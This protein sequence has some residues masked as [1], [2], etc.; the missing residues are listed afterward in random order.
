MAKIDCDKIFVK[1]AKPTSV[2]GQ[3]VMDGVMM[4]GNGRIALAMRIPSGEIYLKSEKKNPDSK[5]MK[6]PFV[7]GIV[8]FVSSLVV[9]MGKL[10]ESADVLA[11]YDP[12]IQEEEKGKVEIWIE[13]KF[14]KKA[15]WNLMMGFSLVLALVIT[16][17][18][19]VIAPTAA[20]N[21][22]KGFISN[23]IVLNLIEGILRIL[24]F[25]LYILAISRMKD[26]KTLFQY[27]GAEHKT[28]HCYENGLELTPDNAS[29]FYTL[30]PR[31]GTSFMVFVL[32]ISLVIFSF[33]GWPNIY[34]RI[35]SRLLLLPVIAGISY[36]VLKWAG[37]SDS[38]V[39]K[40]LSY[41]GLMLQKLTTAEPTVGQLE[42]AITALEAVLVSEDEPTY[43]GFVERKLFKK[44]VDEPLGGPPVDDNLKE[45]LGEEAHD[46]I[47]DQSLSK[48]ADP[49]NIPNAESY[50]QMFPDIMKKRFNTD[51][52]TVRNTLTWGENLLALVENGR[53]EAMIIFSYIT[54]MS[55]TDVVLRGK[56]MLSEAQVNDYENAIRERLNGKPLQYI[57]KVQE[58]MNCII[59]VNP[60]VLIPRLDSE[61]LADS[62]IRVIREKSF[63]QPE[64]LDMCTGSGALGI[65]IG[66]EISDAKLTLTDVD[67]DAL[68]TA[69]S[70]TQLN[71]VFNRCSFV[72]GDMFDAIL[73]DK[74]YDVIV[75]NPPYIASEEVD[76]LTDD[77]KNYEP[78][79]ALD[80]GGDGLDFYR[81]IAENAGEH[82][83][84][85]GILALEI[86][87]DQGE[88]VPYL[89]YDSGEFSNI[90]VV[91]DLNGLDRVVMAERCE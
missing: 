28:I 15:A 4:Q 5:V 76:K 25:V 86:G 7:R 38:K 62:V 41:P 44:T 45:D 18:G 74:K 75:S 24:I 11:E 54:G 31:C 46:L 63:E 22:F 39:V 40:I 12:E 81:I 36:E 20:V 69:I 33:L 84:D 85:G 89:L 57:T 61:V 35:A 50:T 26:I 23:T 14:G 91:K 30:H 83:K 56:E 90:R 73:E 59:K 16:I 53:N 47:G 79:K 68:S 17:V 10:M 72:T 48:L 65:S 55:R 2:G 67:Q 27:H 13:S 87:C 71:N 52:G 70:N 82:L 9:G 21:L 42:I 58:F 32:V 3:A 43:E 29:Q 78:R 80:G 66:H 51:A 6:I 60:S 64:I 19:F 34:W 88:S 1:G 8:A 49:V 37:R 77:V